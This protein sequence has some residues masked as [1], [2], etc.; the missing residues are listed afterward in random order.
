[1]SMIFKIDLVTFKS[2][3]KNGFFKWLFSNDLIKI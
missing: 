2:D 1:M 3:W